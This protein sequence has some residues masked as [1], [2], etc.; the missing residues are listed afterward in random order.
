LAR[1]KGIHQM[2]AQAWF[3]DGSYSRT[4]LE[5]GSWWVLQIGPRRL[6]GSPPAPE[7]S[8]SQARELC[9]VLPSTA[10]GD[11]S[12]SALPLPE[13]GF[14]G[15]RSRPSP[16]AHHCPGGYLSNPRQWIWLREF[17]G[18]LWTVPLV[19][20]QDALAWVRCP[21][22]RGYRGQPGPQVA[23][24]PAR[25]LQRGSLGRQAPDSGASRRRDGGILA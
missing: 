5:A 16:P 21:S 2:T 4:E 10:K 7:A 24:G 22:L 23:G 18:I 25:W 17:G 14:H 1:L 3:P 6:A 15:D 11:E 13:A 9:S 8:G 20:W 19:S 12:P